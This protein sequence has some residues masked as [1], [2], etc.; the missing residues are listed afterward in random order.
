[1]FDIVTVGHFAID[2]IKSART[3]SP[4]PTLGGP[5]A[6]VS[7]AAAK[8]GAKVSVVSKVGR[9]FPKDYF[10]LL[11]EN[12]IDLSGLKLVQDALTTKFVLTYQNNWKRTLQ[13]KNRAPPISACDYSLLP[14]KAIHVAPI[15]NEIFMDTILRLRKSTNILSLDPQGF[16]RGFDARGNVYLKR[17]LEKAVLELIDIY[18]SSQDEVKMVTETNDIEL[19]AEKIREFGVKIVIITRGVHGSTLFFEKS[20]YNVPA[21]QPN[22][23]L[24][25]TGAGD[26][27]IGAFLAEYLRGGDPLWCACVGSACASFVVEGIGSE[28]FGER[29]ETY[30]RAKEIYEKQLRN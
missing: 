13:L 12:N 26:A 19:A 15:A 9:D 29:Q 17:W 11:R 5:P 8:L 3:A 7:L 23:V 20:S 22:L 6:Y 30:E 28:R 21:Y 2:V 1:V 25:P 4:K 24:D 18:K 10:K 14:T 16:V 27:F